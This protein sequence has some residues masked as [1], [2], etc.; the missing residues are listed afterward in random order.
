MKKGYKINMTS[1]WN[2]VALERKAEL[3]EIMSNGNYSECLREELTTVYFIN[4]LLL[5]T[6]QN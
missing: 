2:E 5:I 1:I 3:E 6:T 4:N